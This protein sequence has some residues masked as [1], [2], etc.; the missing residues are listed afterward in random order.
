MAELVRIFHGATVTEAQ[1]AVDSLVDRRHPLIWEAGDIKRVLD[2]T[3]SKKDQTLVLLYSTNRWL[4]VD[5]LFK[6]VEYTS[7]PD[8]RSKVLVPH[9]KARHVEFEPAQNRVRITPLGIEYVEQN[10]L[11]TP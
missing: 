3:M 9:H 5:R 6:W 11:G 10:L 7:L 1:E 4:E 8:F 2:P